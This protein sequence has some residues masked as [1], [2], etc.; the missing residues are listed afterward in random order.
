MRNGDVL[1]VTKDGKEL[2]VTY[3][4]YRLVYSNLGWKPVEGDG[5]GKVD[6]G[7]DHENAHDDS[8]LTPA[9]IEAMTK[10]QVEAELD[11]LVAAGKLDKSDFNKR[12]GVDTLKAV[13]L[14]AIS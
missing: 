11:K 6:P 10:K 2:R 1:R 5:H 4:A 9:K 8:A 3:K 7:T 13:L 12:D 14:D